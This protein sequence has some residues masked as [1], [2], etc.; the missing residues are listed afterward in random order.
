MERGPAHFL[1]RCAVVIASF[2][3]IAGIFNILMDPYL[4]FN[5]PRQAGLNARKPASE[6]Q[7]YFIKAYEVLREKPRTVILG[8]SNVALGFDAQSSAWPVED[9]PVYNLGLAN[10]TTL[11]AFRYLQHVIAQQDVRLVVL[12]L[13]FRDFLRSSR[14]ASRP[15]YEA[16]LTVSRDGSPTRGLDHQRLYDTLFATLS[17]DASLDSIDTLTGNFS[18]DSSDVVDGSWDYRFYRH[19]TQELGSYPLM[20]LGDYDYSFYYHDA[21]PDPQVM[22]TVR[23]ILQ[24]CRQKGTDIIVVLDP[25]HA[26]ELELFDHAGKWEALEAWKRGLTALVA[27]SIE[28][29]NHRVELWDFYGYDPYSTEPIPLRHTALQWFWTPS[30]YTHALS[31]IMLRRIFGTGTTPDYGAELT[32]QSIDDRLQQVRAAQQR[33]RSLQDQ[34]VNRMQTIYGLATTAQSD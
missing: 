16:R 13:E 5:A 25:S 12:A 7:Q 27:Q 28:G 9:R 33:Y 22:D 10:S 15:N 1:K 24:L 3:A 18:G 4:L 32:P 11:I 14:K 2:A 23:D 20:V 31:D 6:D 34:D 19:L 30:H 29:N 21:R 8:S 17:L 26:D